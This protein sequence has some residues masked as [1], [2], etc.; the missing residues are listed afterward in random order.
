MEGKA[1]RPNRRQEGNPEISNSRKLPISIGLEG[2][3]MEVLQS[4]EA[5][6]ATLGSVGAETREDTELLPK[7]YGIIKMGRNSLVHF[8]CA[9]ESFVTASL[10]PS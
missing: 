2:L 6:T 5:R 3:K 7:T 9:L 1:E 8:L 4:P 10:W